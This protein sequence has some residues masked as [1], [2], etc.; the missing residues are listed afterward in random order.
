LKGRKMIRVLGLGFALLTSPTLAQ[1]PT[2]QFPTTTASIPLPSAIQAQTKFIAGVAG[3]ST[4]ITA[5][6]LVPGIGSRVAW[7]AGT[8][9]NCGSDTTALNSVETYLGGAGAESWGTGQGAL[10][11]APQGY[12]ICLTIG[13]AAVGG[14]VAY[15]QF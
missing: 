15:G 3:K 8:G 13:T 10:M 11:V 7:T 12:D 9:T 2:G 1:T 4:Y 14:T 5:V 6:H